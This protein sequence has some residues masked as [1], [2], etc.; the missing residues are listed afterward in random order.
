MDKP[1]R[2]TV[3]V[4]VGH[5]LKTRPM[6]FY[7][8]S[9][10]EPYITYLEQRAEAAEAEV[11]D[12]DKTMR[13]YSDQLVKVTAELVA[14][15]AQLAELAKQEPVK[16]D[17]DGNPVGFIDWYERKFAG[18]AFKGTGHVADCDDAWRAAIDYR[19]APAAV[20]VDLVPPMKDDSIPGKNDSYIDRCDGWNA[21]RAEMLRRIE[22]L[23]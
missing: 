19:P 15:Q 8:P 1:I 2:R 4:C 13:A 10:V 11:E 23:K 20:P 17:E 21:C 9:E 12:T 5:S 16:E 6:E 14:A 18:M 3:G 22:E 7:S